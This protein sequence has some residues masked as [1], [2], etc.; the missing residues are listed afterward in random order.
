MHIT[1][2]IKRLARAYV[3]NIIVYPRVNNGYIDASKFTF[4]AHPPIKEFDEYAKP[5]AFESYPVLKE[6]ILLHLNHRDLTLP[7][8]AVSTYKFVDSYFDGKMRLR[9]AKRKEVKLKLAKY[10]KFL[11][12]NGIDENVMH[13]KHNPISSRYYYNPI[14]NAFK[15]RFTPEQIKKRKKYQEHFKRNASKTDDSRT[16]LRQNVNVFLGLKEQAIEAKNIQEALEKQR[17]LRIFDAM[18][19]SVRRN[20]ATELKINNR[21]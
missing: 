21:C 14:L 16:K 18:R 19:A 2:P 3:N 10:E 1:A 17:I 5:L 8:I 15:I 13:S 7:S 20:I 6:T 11:E 9:P 4:Y 12:K